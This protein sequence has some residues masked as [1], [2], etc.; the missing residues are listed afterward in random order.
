V[1]LASASLSRNRR[2][3]VSMSPLSM[4]T[5]R[6][7]L[8]GGCHDTIRWSTYYAQA[9]VQ[10]TEATE[11]K[12]RGPLPG[13]SDEALLAATK[14][15]LERS[16]FVGALP[17]LS[18]TGT[19]QPAQVSLSPVLDIPLNCVSLPTTLSHLPEK[20]ALIQPHERGTD[21]VSPHATG[22]APTRSHSSLGGVKGAHGE[23]TAIVRSPSSGAQK[24]GSSD[25]LPSMPYWS[26]MDPVQ[27][28]SELA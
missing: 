1:I 22:S 6:N 10:A 11:P 20:R 12:R 8:R 16:P 2:S 4:E 7:S 15:D 26:A 19:V 18:V 21:G 23:E 13:V 14:N 24:S 9:S 3:T 27:S 5:A 28:P 25:M 17:P